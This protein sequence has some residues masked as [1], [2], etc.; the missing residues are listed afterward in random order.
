[1][2]ACLA[3]L[4]G[5][6]ITARRRSCGKDDPGISRV[7][8]RIG[9]DCA[10]AHDTPGAAAT[11]DVVQGSLV[12][13]GKFVP[14]IDSGVVAQVDRKRTRSLIRAHGLLLHFAFGDAQM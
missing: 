3:R 10:D 5:G 12:V 8:L 6:P 1:V 14:S 13:R 7:K 4:A 11:F 2:A 9:A